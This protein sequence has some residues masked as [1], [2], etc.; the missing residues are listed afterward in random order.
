MYLSENISEVCVL[1]VCNQH[2]TF[3]STTSHR[4]K[5]VDTAL[6]APIVRRHVS[7]ELLAQATKVVSHKTMTGFLCAKTHCCTLICLNVNGYLEFLGINVV[8]VL[9]SWGSSHGSEP[10]PMT[11]EEYEV[12]WGWLVAGTEVWVYNQH[13]GCA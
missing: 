13:H 1:P 11:A 6:P 10:L 9:T 3:V 5:G 8:D 12:E 4:N 7:C 2:A